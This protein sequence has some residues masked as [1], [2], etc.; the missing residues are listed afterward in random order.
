M[1]WVQ[2]LYSHL[3]VQVHTNPINFAFLKLILASIVS[4]GVG[5]GFFRAV[6][7][8]VLKAEKYKSATLQVE[9][10]WTANQAAGCT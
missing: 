6:I 9:F 7:C 4:G 1:I 8:H 3:F 2:S 5:G 10:V